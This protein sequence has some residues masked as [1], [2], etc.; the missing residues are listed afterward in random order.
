VAFNN[1]NGIQPAGALVSRT[2]AQLATTPLSGDIGALLWFYNSLDPSLVYRVS[3]D[4]SQ[5]TRIAA[6][7]GRTSAQLTGGAPSSNDAALSGTASF[8]DVSDPTKEY[9]ISPDGAYYVSTNTAGSTA[10]A[11]TIAGFGDS[12]TT[13]WNHFMV[14]TAITRAAG[15]ATATVAAHGLS[16]GQHVSIFGITADPTFNL[17]DVVIT[18]DVADPTNKFTYPCPGASSTPTLDPI[19]ARVLA[20]N[21]FSN[22][23]PFMYANSA[24]RGALVLLNNF[25]H[26]SET[27]AMM[28]SRVSAA[29]QCA[30]DVVVYLGGSNDVVTGSITAATTIANDIAIIR[31]LISAGKRVVLCT[32]PPLGSGHAQVNAAMP[33]MVIVNEARRGLAQQYR[34]QVTIADFWQALVD[35]FTGTA[36]ANV[37]QTDNVHWQTYGARLAGLELVKALPSVVPGHF[38]TSSIADYRGKFN[39]SPNISPNIWGGSGYADLFLQADNGTK[40]GTL[41]NTS[42]PPGGSVAGV[43][44][45]YN[46]TGTGGTGDVYIAPDADG[47]G[48]AQVVNWNPTTATTGTLTIQQESA[49]S[50]AGYMVAG[51]KYQI[52]FHLKIS[53]VTSYVLYARCRVQGIFDGVTLILGSPMHSDIG[54]TNNVFTNFDEYIVGP[55]MIVPTNAWAACSSLTVEVIIGFGAN[56]AG[57][58]TTTTITVSR[59]T[60]NK[61][62]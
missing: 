10:S 12:L 41:T 26:S 1:I 20:I 22:V 45:T 9:R 42:S 43:L 31:A 23:S 25:G 34:G 39:T 19:F 54:A 46:V 50:M 51:D 2:T 29:C 11:V 5:Y 16:T 52:G 8:Y 56:P 47:V 59:M 58:P 21:W 15:I 27:T 36:K 40:G 4:G 28:L 32:I 49:G 44:G 55:T 6:P 13:Y 61:V 33:K 3:A 48:Y 57:T 30:A 24:L 35:P 37:L 62:S 38:L 17:D 14:P 53:G 60:F 7:I 18:R